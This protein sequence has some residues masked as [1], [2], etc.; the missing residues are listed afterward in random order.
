MIYSDILIIRI[1]EL[2][3]IKGLS[4]N[5]LA[6]MSD[7]GQSTLDN[8]MQGKTSDPRIKT[9]HKIANCFNMTISEFL[10]IQGINEFSFDED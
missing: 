1:K 9:L 3:G 6:K 10:D 5:K 7:V 4:I 2:C 8:I